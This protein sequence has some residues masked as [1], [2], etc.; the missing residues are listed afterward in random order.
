MTL[1]HHLLSCLLLITVSCVSKWEKIA[2]GV[3]PSMVRKSGAAEAT[4][5]VGRATYIAH[6]GRCHEYQLP[7]S[8]SDKDW[9]VVVPGMA[10]NASLNKQQ[11]DAVRAYLIAAKSG[12]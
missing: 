11:E 4:L 2:P 10:W 12:K 1:R 8:V 7:D 6:C 9:H 3:T 5:Q